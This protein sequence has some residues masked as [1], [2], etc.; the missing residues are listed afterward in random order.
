ME[1]KRDRGGHTDGGHSKDGPKGTKLH[2]TKRTTL[3]DFFHMK[4]LKWPAQ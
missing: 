2:V 1:C 3:H 4:Y